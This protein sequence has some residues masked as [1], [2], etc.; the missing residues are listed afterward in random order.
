MGSDADSVPELVGLK[1][2]GDTHAGVHTFFSRCH[3]RRNAG[4]VSEMA[5]LGL[6]RKR[7]ITRDDRR[8]GLDPA[9]F[10]RTLF[11]EAGPYEALNVQ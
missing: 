1:G 10:V 2:R 3:M 7:F 5:S 4:L 11:V 8:A 6:E 9:L